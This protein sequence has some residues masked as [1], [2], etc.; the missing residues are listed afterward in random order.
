MLF[1]SLQENHCQN[2]SI[3]IWWIWI[4]EPIAYVYRGLCIGLWIYRTRHEST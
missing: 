2:W 3:R 4:R 1:F